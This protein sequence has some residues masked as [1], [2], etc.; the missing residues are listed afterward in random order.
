MSKVVVAFRH[1][2]YEDLGVWEPVFR[3]AGYEIRYFEAGL[4]GIESMDVVSP[5]ILVIL[6]GP[7]GVHDS[8][9]FPFIPKEIEHIRERIAVGRPTLGS[10]LGSQF[11]AAALG[12][13]V[14]KA[15]QKEMGYRKL[16]LT[17]EG[18]M[19]PIRH[20]ADL[21]VLEW[22][23]DMSDVPVGARLL[24]SSDICATQGFALGNHVLAVQFH[25][26]AVYPGLERWII[27]GFQDLNEYGIDV[28][29]FREQAK[30]LASRLTAASQAM[31]S[32][33]LERLERGAIVF[34]Y[35]PQTLSR[36][37][38]QFL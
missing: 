28:V 17:G 25:P 33:W 3:D 8:H 9:M 23:T 13:N 34:P 27:S 4:G 11:I 15:P 24:A 2:E 29:R 38:S 12:A 36:T 21:P 10:C 32:E 26:E 7:I 20:F 19:S 37:A 16:K 5:D 31:L 35:A 30:T 6:G 14:Y 18:L 1:V 22:H